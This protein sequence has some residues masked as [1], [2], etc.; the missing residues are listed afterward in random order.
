MAAI[1]IADDHP[2]VRQGLKLLLEMERDFRVTGEAA[3]GLEAIRLVEDKAPNILL[4]DLMMPRLHGLEV[5]RQL[6]QR[7]NKTKILVLSMT[8]DETSIVETFDA[9]AD[10]YILKTT[11]SQ[12]LFA[13][14]RKVCQGGNH[15]RQAPKAKRTRADI[16][17]SVSLR[18]RAVLQLTAEGYSSAQIAARL[19]ISPRTVET[20]RKNIMQKLELHSQ[21]DLVR[22]AIRRKI[23]SP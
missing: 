17:D 2:V 9:G 14:I 11:G 5:I 12:E 19:F 18:E 21:T 4:L 6:R 16:Y 23:I 7:K 3:D 22:F 8:E 13:A 1:V 15:F 20:H 10:G